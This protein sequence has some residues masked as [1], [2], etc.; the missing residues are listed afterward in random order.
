MVILVLQ[1]I[2]I[3]STSKLSIVDVVAVKIAISVRYLRC[4]KLY[5]LAEHGP[6]HKASALGEFFLKPT[7]FV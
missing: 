3:V 1:Q 7:G 5:P 2:V 4:F 6:I